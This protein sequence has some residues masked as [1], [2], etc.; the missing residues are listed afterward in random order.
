MWTV[1]EIEARIAELVAEISLGRLA[2]EEV[3]PEHTLLGELGLDS[4]DY[5]TVM[6]DCEEWLDGKVDE[7]KVD[8]RQVTT[9]HLLAE[10]LH[11]SQP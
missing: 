7:A 4:M 10:L 6:L 5:A 11:R 3:R 2:P 9:V 8:W 1:E